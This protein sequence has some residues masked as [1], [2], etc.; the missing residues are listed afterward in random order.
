MYV[1]FTIQVTT[2][3]FRLLWGLGFEFMLGYLSRNP[4]PII[5]GFTKTLTC[6]NESKLVESPL[7]SQHSPN[8]LIIPFTIKDY[9][10]HFWL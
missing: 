1:L 3:G 6:K 4:E 9:T 10:Y 7:A 2:A 8:V 5:L